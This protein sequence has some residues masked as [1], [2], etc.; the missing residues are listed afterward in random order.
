MGI[1][2][3]DERTK[4]WLLEQRVCSCSCSVSGYDTK[5]SD[6]SETK[7]NTEQFPCA[8]KQEYYIFHVNSENELCISNSCTDCPIF[9]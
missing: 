5:S 6:E 2:S 4:D 7:G 8:K 1:V 3:Q 9:V